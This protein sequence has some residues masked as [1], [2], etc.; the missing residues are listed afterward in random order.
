MLRTPLLN[1]QFFDFN[2]IYEYVLR[3]NTNRLVKS[4]SERLIQPS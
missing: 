4:L 2:Q 3:L 1:D